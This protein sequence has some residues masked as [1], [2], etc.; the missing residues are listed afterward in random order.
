MKEPQQ[1]ILIL[2]IGI[3]AAVVIIAVANGGT[4]LVDPIDFEIKEPV[5]IPTQTPDTTLP[6]K[7]TMTLAPDSIDFRDEDFK[8]FL[9]HEASCRN[10]VSNPN[11]FDCRRLTQQLFYSCDIPEGYNSLNC[12]TIVSGSTYNQE[13]T[14]TCD[15]TNTAIN[16]VPINPIQENTVQLCCSLNYVDEQTGESMTT[17]EVCKTV[18]VGPACQL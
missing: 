14:R 4:I 9:S 3:V 17:N 18:V 10:C 15:R 1:N 7:T 13:Y 5:D 12:R 11:L 6:P 16:N 8:W 2:V